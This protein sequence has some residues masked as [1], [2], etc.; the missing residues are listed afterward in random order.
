[1]RRELKQVG[2]LALAIAALHGTRAG[3][4]IAVEGRAS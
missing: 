1:M 2:T 4:Q 3:A